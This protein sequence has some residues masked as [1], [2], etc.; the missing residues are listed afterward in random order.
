MLRKDD[1]LRP[2]HAAYLVWYIAGKR[3]YGN[4]IAF[5][6]FFSFLFVFVSILFFMQLKRPLFLTVRLDFWPFIYLFIYGKLFA[7]ILTASFVIERSK[8]P[9]L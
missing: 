8:R 4:D 3:S 6:P 5:F 7:N 9:N 2:V 1:L